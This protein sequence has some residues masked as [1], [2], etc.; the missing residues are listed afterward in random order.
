MSE[1]RTS[2]SRSGPAKKKW[3]EL[4]GLA[5]EV[6]SK[7]QANRLR[8]RLEVRARRSRLKTGAHTKS[9]S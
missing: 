4:R 2:P 9:S 1:E 7:D 5:Y 8:E 6:L 3:S